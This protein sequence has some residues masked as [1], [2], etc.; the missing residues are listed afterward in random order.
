MKATLAFLQ[1]SCTAQISV[2]PRLHPHH[3]IR[4]IDGQGW[5]AGVGVGETGEE[6][7]FGVYFLNASVT[8]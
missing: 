6:L 2:A 5:G 3:P 4:R 1:E 7:Y 8:L